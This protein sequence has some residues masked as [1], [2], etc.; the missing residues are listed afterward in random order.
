MKLILLLL[1]FTLSC[2][3]YNSNTFDRDRYGDLELVGSA[4]FKASYSILQTRCMN[5]HEHAQW[6]EFTNESDWLRPDLV[7]ASDVN[8]SPLIN[9]IIN[10]GG[11]N[12]NMP[13]GG[14]ALPPAEYTTLETWVL[15]IP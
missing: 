11:S 13:E 7:I 15:N 10:F 5:C 14:S 9:R 3:D 2:Q 6:S 1:F 4:N 12:S 8:N